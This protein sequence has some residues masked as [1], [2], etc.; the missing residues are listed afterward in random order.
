MKAILILVSLFLLHIPVKSQNMSHDH[1][2]KTLDTLEKIESAAYREYS[3]SWEPGDTVAVR[4]NSFIME[5]NNP[6]DS[7]IGAT[8]RRYDGIDTTRLEFLYDGDRKASIYHKEKGA[9]VD[10][11][12]V[13]R[14]PFRLVTPPF[15]N[16]AKNIV[17][18][19]LETNDSIDVDLEDLGDEYHFK[20]VIHEEEQ[21]EFFGKAYIIPKNPYM[22]DPTSIYEL[23]IRKSDGLPY[24]VRREMSHNISESVCSDVTL[25]QLQSGGFTVDDYIP[26]GYEVRKY[27]EKSNKK[28]D[29]GLIGKKAP[30]WS[31]KDM[32][33][34]TVS[35]SGLKGKVVVVGLT[36]IG[37]GPCLASIPFLN[38]LK[39]DFSAEKFELVVIETWK[40]NTYSLQN[41]AQKH[42]IEY[43]FLSGNEDIVKNYQTP[44]VPV[45]FI[46]DRESIVR[47]V[48]N[49]YALEKTDQEIAEAIRK[50]L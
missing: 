13:R 41:Y 45:F 39:K 32:N 5:F 35:L 27:G 37:C 36:G 47:K 33:E 6:A 1:L 23:W 12:T 16:Y 42:H 17:R 40:R 46:L 28:T 9:I 14:L 19:A 2:K 21:V 44:A 10:D 30:D 18:Y 38:K 29:S 22:L 25:N 26:Q 20:L 34:Q 15:F 43:T 7:T 31:L 48:I 11:F 4:G 50:L 24:K 3:C 8:L 49:G